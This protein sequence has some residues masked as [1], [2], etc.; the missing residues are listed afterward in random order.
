MTHAQI[1]AVFVLRANCGNF[2]SHFQKAI[3]ISLQARPK[4]E[5][6]GCQFQ[7]A[8]AKRSKGKS[9]DENKIIDDTRRHDYCDD[10]IRQR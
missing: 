1:Q 2:T 10:K 4:F 7:Q 6:S 5:T 8:P 3:S 9:A